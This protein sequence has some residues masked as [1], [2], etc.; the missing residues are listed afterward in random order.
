MDQLGRVTTGLPGHQPLSHRTASPHVETLL[1]ADP[2]PKAPALAAAV[3]APFCIL[4]CR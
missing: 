1:R 3:T 2:T 4:G